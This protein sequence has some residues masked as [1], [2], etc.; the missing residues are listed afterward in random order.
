MYKNYEAQTEVDQMKL[1][2]TWAPIKNVDQ[3]LMYF[4][5]MT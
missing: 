2:L 3:L 1:I 5:F 4:K